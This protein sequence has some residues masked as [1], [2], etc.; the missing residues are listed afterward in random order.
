MGRVSRPYCYLFSSI[1]RKK[2]IDEKKNHKK[3]YGEM[4]EAFY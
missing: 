4:N 2:S 1:N 3:Q